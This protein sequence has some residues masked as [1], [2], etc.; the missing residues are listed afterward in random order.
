MKG[1]RLS[2]GVSTERQPETAPVL[3]HKQQGP[4]TW[5]RM[6]VFWMILVLQM[7]QG[8]ASNPGPSIAV[9]NPTGV[10]GKSSLLAGLG[11]DIIC[12]SETHLS[13]EG[14]P[15]FKKELHF[16]ANKMKLSHGWP[17]P[18]RSNTVGA[19]GGRPKGV[20]FATNYPVR[21]HSPEWPNEVQQEAR[22]HVASFHV[23]NQWV[24]GGLAY[25]YAELPQTIPTKQATNSLIH[26]LSEAVVHNCRGRR[27]V[28]GDWNQPLEDIECVKQWEDL[29]WKEV[30]QWAKE[31]LHQVPIATCKK[32]TV[33]DFLFLSPEF[34][35]DLEGVEVGWDNFA[36]HATLIAHFRNF[37]SSPKVPIWRKPAAV[38]WSLGT[39]DT[40]SIGSAQPAQTWTDWY[41][42]VW[43][44][45]ETA[46]N[47]HT[48]STGHTPLSE[49]QL[50][51]ASVFEVKWVDP[52]T[53]PLKPARRGDFQ[54]ALGG[55]HQGHTWRVKQVRRLQRMARL[56]STDL[57]TSNS[58]QH[59]L[60]LWRAILKAP[61]FDGGFTEWWN[62]KDKI[63]PMAPSS[64]GAGLPQVAQVQGLYEE[65][66]IEVRRLEESIGK[67]RKQGAAQR[68]Q[69][70]RHIVFRDIRAEA[71]APVSTLVRQRT[72]LVQRIEA[73]GR[74]IV[75]KPDQVLP[76]QPVSIGGIPLQFQWDGDFFVGGHDVEVAEGQHL[77]QF[78]FIGE[79]HEMFQQFRNEWEPRW[80]KHME[81]IPATWDTLE[82]FGRRMLPSGVWDFPDLT[83]AMWKDSLRK[84]KKHT[85]TGSD[86]VSR[87]DLLA[88]PDEIS[89]KMVE[90]FN[91]LE[92]GEDWPEQL[93]VG[94]INSLEKCVGAQTVAQYRPITI[95]PVAYR[96]WSSIRA[97]QALQ[98]ISRLAPHG[99]LGNMP[100]K[101]TSQAWHQLQQ[102][103]EAAQMDDQEVAGCTVDL[104]KCFNLL[105]RRPIE[106]MAR[107]LGIKEGI[108]VAWHSYIQRLER[109]FVIRGG[110][111]G[112]IR[113]VTG[114][115][116]GC[117]LS[118]VAMAITNMIC[119][120]WMEVRMPQIS[121]FSYV[122]DWQSLAS[123]A[124]EALQSYREIEAFCKLLDIDIDGR[125]SFCWCTH[126]EGRKQL[127]QEISVKW[128][129]RELGGHLNFTKCRTNYTVVERI[130]NVQPCWSKLARSSAPQAQKKQAIK[131]GIW[132]KAL[133]GSA[134][135]HI[136][137]H[138]FSQ[139]RT[140]M[141]RGL[142]IGTRGANPQIQW[143]LIDSV[144]YDP[145]YFVLWD[146]VVHYRRYGNADLMHPVL[147]K[148][149]QGETMPTPGPAAVMLRRLHS[150]GWHWLRDGLC[151]DHHEML[152]DL[153]GANKAEIKHRMRIAWQVHASHQVS[154]RDTFQ[155]LPEA[156][157]DLT[158]EGFD[159]LEA[160]DRGLLRCA[161][162]GTKFTNDA[163][164]HMGKVPHVGCSFCGDE[165]SQFHRHWQC[166]AF[167][168]SRR[169]VLP[170]VDSTP[171]HLPKA[172]Y[173]HGWLPRSPVW[174]KMK[175]ELL[176]V[177]DT[178]MEFQITDE[179][180]DQLPSEVHL[181]TDGSC[182]HPTIPSERV[183]TWAV[184][185]G[186]FADTQTF[187]TISSGGVPG[188]NQTVIRGEIMAAISALTFAIVH[189]RKVWLW[190]DNAEVVSKL[191]KG[192]SAMMQTS[193]AANADL[194]QHLGNLL[195]R[196][197]ELF[198]GVVKVDS[199]QTPHHADT[200][201][202]VW[203]IQGNT[204][205][206]KAAEQAR[207]LLPPSLWHTWQTLTSHQTFL[208]ALREKT[209]KMFVDI[210]SQAISW[211]QSQGVA[212]VGVEPRV[213]VHF[214]E[215][216]WPFFLGLTADMIDVNLRWPGCEKFFTWVASLDD[217]GETRMVTWHQV[218]VD[219][220]LQS[221]F[222]GLLY[223]NR[224]WTQIASPAALQSF[225]S[226]TRALARYIQEVGKDIGCTVP[227]RH[228]RPMSHTLYFW[229]GCVEV[230]WSQER[231]ERVEQ[232]FLDR[233]SPPYRKVHQ[234]FELPVRW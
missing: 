97:R 143:S 24:T 50:G 125:K 96:N 120:R 141:M 195:N 5:G 161:L 106:A 153:L 190:V 89:E 45:I 170:L 144:E 41:K 22:L 94:L 222:G 55:G 198:Q 9:V 4:H 116:E 88:L 102:L 14:V 228:Q 25:G 159:L 113:S 93:V 223:K 108:V 179:Q 92:G 114:Y 117:P 76:D 156:D 158:M 65:M 129:C 233:G 74:M 12:I 16:A 80:N 51:R 230:V 151:L 234:L 107:H 111:G 177:P 183:A 191:R 28:A 152:V 154:H 135:V 208:R 134:I 178:H 101:T 201:T 174:W 99:L 165:D 63:L 31:N 136:G 42:Q 227:I 19:I 200:W 226:N 229:A 221:D 180:L 3:T 220:L 133:H 124:L 211:F 204:H 103:I 146:S 225:G 109:R 163:L 118:V 34:L 60:D 166:R 71:A 189:Q 10:M 20:G 126:A 81:R 209:H 218:Y 217:E 212:E 231:W 176:Q 33:R 66:A 77:Q 13:A 192:A 17:A 194:W 140:G 216:S 15:Q 186:G 11:A 86:G 157:F 172:F 2:K 196:A 1:R 206:D 119:H 132:P 21:A 110:T 203:A 85:A 207:Q 82:E 224:K 147:N 181:F 184:C 49:H 127:K 123:S 139:L 188:W 112:P 175:Q 122:D 193:E 150:I 214:A 142:H 54:S 100:A 47:N 215:R 72:F 91:R 232:Y 68:R 187:W 149:S 75:D 148:L 23:G 70:N 59:L 182:I 67:Q 37:A 61:G 185:V 169:E 155:G 130:Q 56:A 53:T 48:T 38:E 73:D 162:N 197:G 199:H 44:D 43:H 171:V 27:F 205:A 138:H 173:N 202:T 210:G 131:Q 78:E 52:D 58:K 160:A 98:H 168:T 7:F 137:H 105:P 128:H 18:K 69:A 39:A 8:E 30:Q 90:M 64:I 167:E 35:E 115:P 87:A 46:Q 29:G 79:L 84:K 32:S 213:P 6:A 145:E 83:V 40:S 104:V 164:V 26:H 95:L 121:I 219:F 62:K 36:D 57:H